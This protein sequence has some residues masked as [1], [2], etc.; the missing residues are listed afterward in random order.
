[1]AEFKLNISDK[2]KAYKKTIADDA[3]LGKKVGEKITGNLIGL[4]NYELEITGGSDS[5]GFPM[6][7]EI[8]GVLKKRL[9]LRKGPG[10]KAKKKASSHTQKHYH[11]SKR[12]TIRGNTISPSTSQINLKIIKAGTKS[13]AEIFG[14]KEEAKIEEQ[15]EQPKQEEKGSPKE[16]NKEQK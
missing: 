12:K 4:P 1:M 10:F 5:S 13:L 6:R 8:E 16:I 15:K 3:L 2:G 14:I 9:V 11:L 7:P